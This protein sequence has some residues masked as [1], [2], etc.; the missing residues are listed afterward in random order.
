MLA[1]H[2]LLEFSKGEA[3]FITKALEYYIDNLWSQKENEEDEEDLDEVSEVDAHI[4]VAEKII[5]K[6]KETKLH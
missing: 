1:N 4:E 5:T 3:H 2:M 6:F